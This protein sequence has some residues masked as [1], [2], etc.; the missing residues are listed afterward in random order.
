MRPREHTKDHPTHHGHCHQ[1]IVHCLPQNVHTNHAKVTSAQVRISGGTSVNN[2]M[3]GRKIGPE[4]L[5]ERKRAGLA[6]AAQFKKNPVTTSPITAARSGE[7][8]HISASALKNTI[9]MV[10]KKWD[11]TVAA[12]S[13]PEAVGPVYD[14]LRARIQAMQQ[15]VRTYIIS[16]PDSDVLVDTP[17]EL[18]GDLLEA[19][20]VDESSVQFD[21]EHGKHIQL[22]IGINPDRP[23]VAY[24]GGTWTTAYLEALAAIVLNDHTDF[25]DMLDSVSQLLATMS[26]M[27]NENGMTVLNVLS[28]DERDHCRRLVQVNNALGK[29]GL[30]YVADSPDDSA[31]YH[32]RTK[33]VNVLSRHQ[34]LYAL[35]LTAGGVCVCRY[36]TESSAHSP[37]G[38][39]SPTW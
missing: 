35:L 22:F 10:T 15:M 21:P 16:L 25:R 23:D 13:T 20:N 6:T 17:P 14:A 34:K 30:E 8:L 9:D 11:L 38:S 31:H 5:R 28:A 2:I 27:E 29:Y 32:M 26:H 39:S 12:V 18:V 7:R 36:D 24:M 19:L 37:D 3:N 1:L 33:Q 4:Q